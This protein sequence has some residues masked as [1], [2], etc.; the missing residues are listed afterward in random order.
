M[1]QGTTYRTLL[2]FTVLGNFTSIKTESVETQPLL[3]LPVTKYLIAESG[4]DTGPAQFVQ[5]R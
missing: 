2:T 3:L 5:E 4:R 1:I